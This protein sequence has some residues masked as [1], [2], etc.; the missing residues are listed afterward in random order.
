MLRSGRD[1]VRD[2]KRYDGLT[3]LMPWP[4]AADATPE[5]VQA[6]RRKRS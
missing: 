5:K 2:P 6:A 3:D 4:T 1:A